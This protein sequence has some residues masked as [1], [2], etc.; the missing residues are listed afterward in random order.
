[1]K[2]A[3]RLFCLYILT[4]LLIAAC[5]SRPHRPVEEAP[6]IEEVIEIPEVTEI[7]EVPEITEITEVEE[8]PEITEVIEIEEVIEI[9]EIAEIT[10]ITEV[11][12]IAET[13]D[14]TEAAV[15]IEPEQ[16]AELTAIAE[17]AMAATPPAQPPEIIPT[18]IERLVQRIKRNEDITKHFVLG[19]GGQ[20]SVKADIRDDAGN[21]EVTYNLDNARDTGNSAYEVRF[22]LRNTRTGT[23]IEDTLM[24]RPRAGNAGILLSFD[25]DYFQSWEQHFDL[26]DR[27]GAKVTFF[28]Q[29][30]LNS[31]AARAINRGHDIGYHS[32][33]HTD[34]RGVSRATFNRETIDQA[35]TFRQ[36]GVPLSSFA[37]PYGFSESWMHGVLLRTFGVLRGY[38]VTFRLYRAHEIKS[39]YISSRAIDNTVIPGDANFN[40]IVTSMLRTVKFLDSNWVLP[41]TTHEIS[42]AAWGITPRRLE[43]VL[44]TARDLGLRF[45]R[46]SDF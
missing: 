20:I 4:F 40:R 42:S 34:L 27:Y 24:W 31:F 1:M 35:E 43:F 16:P 37:Y 15:I 14:V 21:F 6:R 18:P 8:V 3:L 23:V 30:R 28:I 25:D 41:L 36:A 11:A 26:F 29:G 13:A 45:Y 22:T 32:L 17:M 10:E 44:R 7:E 19:A 9:P 12:E 33:N 38:G 46:F 2:K 5:A 39:A